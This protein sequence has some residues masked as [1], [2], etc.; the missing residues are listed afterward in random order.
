MRDNLGDTPINELAHFGVKGMKWG[1]RR[2]DAQLGNSGKKS[3]PTTADIKE[4]RARLASANAVKKVKTDQIQSKI[5]WRSE[6]SITDAISKINKIETDALNNPDRVTAARMT[7]GEKLATVLTGGA[8][9]ISEHRRR[10]G[11]SSKSIAKAQAS[12]AYN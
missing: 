12:G 11:G 8:P 7:K 9:Y 10:Y 6:K 4:S 1:V 3:K 5:N 2:T